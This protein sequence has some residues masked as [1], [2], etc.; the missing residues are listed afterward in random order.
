[1]CSISRAARCEEYTICAALAPDDVFTVRTYG[2]RQL[3]D[4]GSVRK[5]RCREPRT[6]RSQRR[7]SPEPRI[8]SQLRYPFRASAAN[9]TGHPR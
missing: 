1:M 5:F 9:Q 4:P 6:C 7:V 2:T 3:Y 8:V